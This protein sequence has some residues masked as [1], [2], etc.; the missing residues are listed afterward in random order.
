MTTSAGI[1]ILLFNR[2]LDNLSDEEFHNYW[3]NVHAALVKRTTILTNTIKRYVQV[4]SLLAQMFELSIR[5]TLF[6]C[7]DTFEP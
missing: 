5:L 1:K 4:R 3:K 7:K 2:K 6:R